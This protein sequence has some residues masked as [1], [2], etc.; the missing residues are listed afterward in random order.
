[1]LFRSVLIKALGDAG[2][3]DAGKIRFPL[4]IRQGTNDFG[5]KVWFYLNYSGQEQKLKSAY[6]DGTELLTGA[7]V[8]EGEDI[9]IP[10][11]GVKI[12]E[13]L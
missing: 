11:W 8:K 13:N 4:I 5:K 3:M 9:K 2:I 12:I 7:L 1:M 10:A 6:G